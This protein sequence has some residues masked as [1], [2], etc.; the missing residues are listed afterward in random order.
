VKD[1]MLRPAP[2]IARSRMLRLVL[3]RIKML[4]PVFSRKK[5]LI[6]YLA[7]VKRQKQN[8]LR[9]QRLKPVLQITRKR[10]FKPVLARC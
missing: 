9:D 1:K 4:K 7:R 8:L 10:M 6:L 2:K 3:L 5:I